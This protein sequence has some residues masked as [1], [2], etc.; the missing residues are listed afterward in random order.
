MIFEKTYNSHIK[1]V[2]VLGASGQLGKDLV[3]VISADRELNVIAL[4]RDIFDAEINIDNLENK[5]SVYN[6]RI[7]INCIATTNVDWCEQNSPI[8]WKIN[9]DFVYRL[10][11][12]CKTNQI[13]LMHISTDY[14]FSGEKSYPYREYEL[15]APKNV[16]GLTKYS[17]EL[18]ISAYLQKY[19][20]FRVSGL[21]GKYGASGKS[22]NFITA[23][24]KLAKEK[25]ELHVVEDQI[26]NPTSTLAVARCIYYFI[27]KNI[28][29]YGVY[30]CVSQDFC[31]WYEFARE[32]LTISGLDAAKVKP[33]KYSNY[34]FK[35][36]RP[37]N[38][39]L[40]TDKIAKYYTMPTW[41]D[42]L[43]EYMLLFNK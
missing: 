40:S 9:A 42:S 13:I 33:V 1:N 32:I 20:I 29:D 7:L 41:Q 24:Q 11:Q 27:N 34:P 38:S 22:G 25:N 30:H 4:T 10:A 26:S 8:A 5:L 37:Q 3:E 36:K 31:S 2:V 21:F 35:A 19:F 39:T 17:G 12:F 18:A 15:A 6:P 16:Y 14:V 28:T 43:K 23:I